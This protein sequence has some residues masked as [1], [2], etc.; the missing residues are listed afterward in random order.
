[1]LLQLSVLD[2]HLLPIALES[3]NFQSKL[4][5]IFVKFGLV[6]L[7]VCAF[8]T[9][10]SALD[11]LLESFD[12]R[13]DSA[14]GVYL[15]LR[16]SALGLGVILFLQDAVNACLKTRSSVTAYHLPLAII[17]KILLAL[18]FG[19][20]FVELV[21]KR[22]IRLSS[23]SLAIWSSASRL[24]CFID[25]EADI[26]QSSHMSLETWRRCLARSR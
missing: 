21:L 19:A 10:D 12:V 6:N 18:L 11:F 4:S 5:Q 25:L 3:S 24:K 13:V 17:P 20:E 2:I 22:S 8:D 23:F 1:M 26:P 9:Y 7:L 14:E 15:E 16:S